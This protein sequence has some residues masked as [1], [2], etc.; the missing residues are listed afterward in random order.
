MTPLRACLQCRN[1][2]AVHSS[3]C[4][5]LIYLHCTGDPAV[6]QFRYLQRVLIIHCFPAG[7]YP[8]H[9]FILH[10]PFAYCH[11]PTD[12]PSR[13]SVLTFAHFLAVSSCSS[14]RSH[15]FLQDRL[16]ENCK[17]KHRYSD[18]KVDISILLRC[19]TCCGNF[20]SVCHLRCGRQ[21]PYYQQR[22]RA[23]HN[24]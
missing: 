4:T 10:N 15:S 19:L 6:H 12:N 22:W 17:G 21:V 5:L 1:V 18:T 16:K 24:P 13:Q 3:C 2:V 11:T 8:P 7:F 9:P 14:V 23:H 20:L